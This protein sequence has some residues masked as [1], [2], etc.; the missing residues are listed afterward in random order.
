MQE[1]K[2]LILALR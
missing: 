2:N 1:S